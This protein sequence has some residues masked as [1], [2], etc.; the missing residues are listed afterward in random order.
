MNGTNLFFRSWLLSESTNNAIDALC[1]Y[2]FMFFGVSDAALGG[3][4]FDAETLVFIGP[5]A[6][7]DSIMYFCDSYSSQTQNR[8]A[9]ISLDE[10]PDLRWR[11]FRRR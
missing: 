5:N 6:Y 1:T 10:L 7:A 3:C 2:E 4:D 11:A 8:I 9:A